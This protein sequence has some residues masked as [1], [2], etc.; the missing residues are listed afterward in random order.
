MTVR[1]NYFINPSSETNTTGW[2]IANG[3]NLSS[4]ADRAWVGTK[5]QKVVY[6]TPRAASQTG[7]SVVDQALIGGQA[8]TLSAYVWVPTGQPAVAWQAL[9]GHT[10]TGAASTTKDAWERIS[11]T[12]TP[13]SNTTASLYILNQATSV[14]GTGFYMD[15]AMMERASSAGTYFDGS[16]VKAGFYYDWT[17]ASNASTSTE[18]SGYRP[19]TNLSTNPSVEVNTTGFAT[20]SVTA[21]QSTD[22]AWVGTKCLKV[23]YNGTSSQNGAGVNHALSITAGVT[24]TFSV[25]VYVPTGQQ[26]A[27]VMVQI[28]GQASTTG[29][30]T[31]VYDSWERLTVTHTAPV[32]GT[33]NYFILNNTTS[34]AGKYFYADAYLIEKAATAG[35]YFDGDTVAVGKTHVWN[36]TT[37]LSSSTQTPQL[38]TLKSRE[39]GAWVTRTA[40]PKVLVGGAWVYKRPKRWNGTAWVDLA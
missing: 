1:T 31:T 40:I 14:A 38:V 39:S 4:S 11:V 3:S 27:V 7:T 32:S 33:A 12:F 13:P 36:G 18:T 19:R 2:N 15:G 37:G 30:A 23:T 34:A 22:R 26:P 28:N 29:T 35:T 24:Y 21:A 16:T 6:D 9:G 17:G 8:Y 25:Y 10:A 5:S 20:F